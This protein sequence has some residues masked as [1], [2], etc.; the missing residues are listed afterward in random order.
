MLQIENNV[1]GNTV[2]VNNLS[3][4]QAASAGLYNHNPESVKS[5]HNKKFPSPSPIK[6]EK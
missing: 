5:S 3:K 2:G 6:K 4:R 1:H